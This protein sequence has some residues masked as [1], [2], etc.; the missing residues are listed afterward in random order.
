MIYK[1]NIYF[2]KY[3]H[4]Y[5][6]SLFKLE[7]KFSSILLKSNIFLYVAPFTYFM[8]GRGGIRHNWN[9]YI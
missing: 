9:E 7:A 1:E 4:S 6:S 8:F 3:V 2:S 5:K